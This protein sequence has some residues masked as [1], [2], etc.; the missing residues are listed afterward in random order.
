MGIDV[1]REERRQGALEG[2][3]AR[4]GRR[5]MEETG[6]REGAAM[7]RVDGPLPS[8]KRWKLQ[9]QLS[10]DSVP[11][12][13]WEQSPSL[14]PT[15]RYPALAQGLL[16]RRDTQRQVSVQDTTCPRA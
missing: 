7:L 13:P 6:W 2:R 5:L 11:V 15:Y 1:P 12:V 10:P 9:L 8:Q 16:C 3:G 4:V 14:P